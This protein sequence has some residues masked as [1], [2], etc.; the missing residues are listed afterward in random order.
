MSLSGARRESDSGSVGT[1][2]LWGSSSTPRAD[3]YACAR[4]RLRSAAHGHRTDYTKEEK[5]VFQ[6]DALYARVRTSGIVT[7]KYNIDGT[8]FEMYDVGGQRNERRKWIHCFEDVTAV[9]F[10]AA[11]SEYDQKLFEDGATNRMIEALELFEEIVGNRCFMRSTIILF[12]N[13]KDL[14]EEKIKKTPINSV[15]KFSDYTGGAD[16]NAG[17]KYFEDKFVAKHH[18]KCG[19][20]AVLYQH[21]TCATDTNNVKIVMDAAKRTILEKNFGEAGLL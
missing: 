1:L 18:E 16:Y 9:I 4:L 3:V 5:D 13:K 20:E 8:I 11:I 14:F 12:L 6:K 17:C 19:P 2:R 21:V 7:E 15:E 10:V